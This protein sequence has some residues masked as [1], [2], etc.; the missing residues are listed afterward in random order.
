MPCAGEERIVTP[1]GLCLRLQPRTGWKFDLH[2]H[3]SP[4]DSSHELWARV[5]G[6]QRGEL[7]EG[8]WGMEGSDGQTCKEATG[9]TGG[10]GGPG[11]PFGP[12]RPRGPCKRKEQERLRLGWE[13]RPLSGARQVLWPRSAPTASG[14][15]CFPRCPGRQHPLFP[16]LHLLAPPHLSSGKGRRDAWN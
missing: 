7:A 8:P 5:H 6:G 11:G 15:S 2:E 4:A 9:L 16:L 14:C 12:S 10:P 3:Q 13:P 1:A